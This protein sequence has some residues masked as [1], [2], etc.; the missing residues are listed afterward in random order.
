MSKTGLKRDTTDKFYTKQ[1]TANYLINRWKEVLFLDDDCLIIE[2][3]AGNGSFF[4]PLFNEDKYHIIGYDIEPENVNIIKGDFLEVEL[5]KVTDLHFIGNPPFGR[6]SSLAKKF[7]KKCAKYG[8]SISFILPK[9]FKKDSFKKTF[10]LDFHLIYEQDIPENSF[11]IEGKDY[12]VECVF[13]IWKKMDIKRQVIEDEDPYK[14]S[15]VKKEEE[16]HFSLRRVGVYAGKISTEIENKSSESHY[17]IKLD[18]DIDQDTFEEEFLKLEFTHNN[19]VGPKS[20]SKQ[21]FI[22]KINIIISSIV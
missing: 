22:K 14:F 15:F 6:Q 16:P 10:P 11:S 21:E 4:I 20:I 8:E 18:E 9:S 2:P 17:F 3:S 19:T 13:Q 5:P 12:N 7:I 1:S